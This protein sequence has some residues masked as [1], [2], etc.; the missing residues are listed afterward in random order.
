MNRPRFSFRPNLQ[1]EDHR[2]AWKI[3]QAVPEGQRNAFLVRTILR[4]VQEEKLEETLR[5]VLREELAV[6][7]SKPVKQQEEEIP[8]EMLRFLDSLV[9]KNDGEDDD[10]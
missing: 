7:S 8:Q 6:V 5:R 9:L 1:N 3:L 10:L 2:R 4:T